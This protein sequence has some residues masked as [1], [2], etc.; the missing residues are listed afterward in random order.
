FIKVY[1]IGFVCGPVLLWAAFRLTQRETMTGVLILSGI[2]L[3]GTLH[4]YG[5]FK[6]GTMNQSLVL[7]QA[8]AGVWT[9]TCLTLSAAMTERRR[10]EAAL[11]EQKEAIEFANKT[12][13]HFLAMLSH[14][15]RTPLTPVMA[16]I[17]LLETEPKMPAEFRESLQ[18]IRRN[19]ELERGL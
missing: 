13:D 2:A 4:G 16:A 15:L 9:L 11:E 14:E 5:P 19:I 6:F 1:P 12:K 3:W 8:W 10:A 18:A 17:D 7:L